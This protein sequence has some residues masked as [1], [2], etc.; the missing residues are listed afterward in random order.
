MQAVKPFL[1]NK[2]KFDEAITLVN[3]E[4]LKSNEKEEAKLWMIFPQIL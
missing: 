4:N 3:N 1:S 2:V